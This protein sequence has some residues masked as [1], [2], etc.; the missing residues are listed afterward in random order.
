MK[1]KLHPLLA[2]FS[3]L[4]ISITSCNSAFSAPTVTSIPTD[5]PAPT[6]TPL[7][8]LQPGDSEHNVTVNGIERSYVLH[9]PA[10][11]DGVQPTP[12]VFM[13]HGFQENP[14]TAQLMTG[15]NDVSDQHGFLVVYPA[16]IGGGWNASACCG[17]AVTQNID[18][19]AFVQ[20][21][22]ADIGSTIKIDQKRI[23]ATGFS[24]GALLSYRLACEMSDTF[25]A[26]GPVAGTMVEAPCEPKV[27]VSIIHI[28]ALNDTAVLYTGGPVPGFLPVED[29]IATW[30]KTD[31]CSDPAQVE[32][33]MNDTLTHTTYGSCAAGIGIEMYV[34]N[35][36]GHSWPSK[37]VWDASQTIWT[38][39]AAHPKP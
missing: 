2:I 35:I 9:T 3:I 36:G 24:N 4:V 5:T 12:I 19:P 16:G 14:S 6:V 31:K 21:I 17:S 20:T 39:I 33:L 10:G 23:Y 15:W 11:M 18:E 1:N 26:I 7:P 27:P 22:L 29:G 30:V 34:F 28:H 38:F 13:F 25:A 32:K 37:Y 8:T